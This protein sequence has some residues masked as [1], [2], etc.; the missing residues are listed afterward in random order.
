MSDDVAHALAAI[1]EPAPGRYVRI[2]EIRA[3]LHQIGVDPC[4]ADD[5][6]ALIRAA[7]VQT[8]KRSRYF[9]ALD[10]RLT[11]SAE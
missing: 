10:V 3:R 5:L 9:L 6:R 11:G 4:P 7:G 2:P 1:L 8:V